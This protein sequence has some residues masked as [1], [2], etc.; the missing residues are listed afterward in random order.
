VRRVPSLLV[1]VVGVV[2]T[3]ACTSEDEVADFGPG[4]PDE[5]AVPADSGLDLATVEEPD[6]V[7][8]P[9]ADLAD[10]GWPEVAAWVKRETDAGRPVVVNFFASWCE[11]CKREL[12][13]LIATAADES[14]AVV[15]VGV[16]HQDQRELGEQ[17]V[18]EYGIDYPTL[19]DA[20]GDAAFA[21][22]A[23]GMPTTVAFDTDGRLAGR[24]IGELTDTS[25]QQL[26]DEV[27]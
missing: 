27:R 24:V 26:L 18:E 17:M 8:P 5:A 2:A 3:T 6:T 13:L 14:D 23:R 15:F 16:D 19:Y 7:P 21:V 11:P 12:P 4:A 25:L 20:A 22:G 1:A 9:D 10:A